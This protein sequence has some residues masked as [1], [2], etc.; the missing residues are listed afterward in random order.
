MRQILGAIKEHRSSLTFEARTNG[1][2]PR[3]SLLPDGG[4][5]KTRYLQACRRR[6]KDWIAFELLPSDHG[7][8]AGG[9][10][11]HLGKNAGVDQ[12]W[13][14]IVYKSRSGKA[15]VLVRAAGCRR[16][17]HAQVLPMNQV[18]AA[19]MPPVHISPI[20]AVGIVLIKEVIRALPEQGSI[21]VIHPVGRRQ[22]MVLRPL[23]VRGQLFLECVLISSFFR[24]GSPH[25]RQN[26]RCS[27]PRL[28]DEVSTR[29]RHRLQIL[30][31][32]EITL[33]MLLG[34][35]SSR[36]PSPAGIST[37]PSARPLTT[38]WYFPAAKP[39]ILTW[40]G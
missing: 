5:S 33:V 12:S 1:H 25:L 19:R 8:I 37:S 2:Q 7:V 4:V 17:S 27:K 3:V 13:D 9:E 21:G 26:R 16:Q 20:C 10:T 18:F 15:A 28:H 24:G 30:R 23:R 6:V 31:Y 32:E 40:I 34:P 14:A 36:T 38:S 22:E 29:K 11:L 39:S 35:I